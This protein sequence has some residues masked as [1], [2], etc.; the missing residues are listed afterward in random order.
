MKILAVLN[1]K[2]GLLRSQ[3]FNDLSA[4][5]KASFG[6]TDE[7]FMV[8]SAP[9]DDLNSVLQEH[10]PSA[11]KILAGGGDGTVSCVADYCI[12]NNKILGVLPG[13]TMN[14]FARS[15]NV[16]LDFEL[17][18]RALSTAPTIKVDY[19]TAN[20][21]IFLHQYSVG[22][23]P[24]LV[25]KRARLSYST[26][27]GKI[28]A[29]LSA[30][31]SMILSSPYF[32]CA[33]VSDGEKW[34]K[35]LSMI[36]VSNNPHSEGHLPYPDNLNT[37]ILGIY[38]AGPLGPGASASLVSDLLLGRWSVNPDLKTSTS[39]EVTL[40]FSKV[41]GKRFALLDGELIKLENEVH[42]KSHAGGLR[43]LAPQRSEKSSS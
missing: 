25:R 34:E 22:M 15:L 4:L 5:L 39:K 38:Y 3:S 35:R 17:A 36:A 26:R 1:P 18:A 7:D 8:T 12:K 33:L 23:Q 28:F 19:G 37:N 40:R 21:R 41:R 27:M 11:T 16:P 31:A 29:S 24:D 43:V 14:L 32:D 10:G 9:P 2:S 30:T 42:I 20:G 6:K 13:G